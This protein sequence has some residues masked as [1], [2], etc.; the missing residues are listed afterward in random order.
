MKERRAVVVIAAAGRARRFGGSQKVL[1]QVGGIPSVCRVAEACERGLGPHRQIVVVG[2][3]GERVAAAL[4]P[5]G[6]REFV[7]QEE[8]R[9][10]GHALALAL[11]H[12]ADAGVHEVYFVCGDKPLLTAESLARLRDGFAASGAAMAFL[13]GEVAGDPRESR[14]GRVVQI[15]RDTPR[16]EVLAVVERAAI[17]ALGEGETLSFTALGGWQQRY[18]RDDLL[19]IRDVNVSAYV[20]RADVLRKHI[21]ELQACPESG[22]YLVT[23]LVRILREHRH[24]VRAFPVRRSEEGIGIDTQEVLQTANAV[25]AGPRGAT[26]SAPPAGPLVARQGVHPGA[27]CSAVLAA[28]EGDAPQVRQAMASIYGDHADGLIE[29]RREAYAAAVRLHRESF[30]ERPVRLF[31]APSRIALNPHCEHQGAWVPYGTHRREL[32][33]VVSP[34]H[35]DWFR[36]TNVDASYQ[37]DL[38]FRLSEE[39]DRAPASWQQGWAAY[40]EDD[41]VTQ[42]RDA[43]ADPR[44]RRWG[45]TGSINFIKAA[46]LRLAME[47][48]R[49]PCGADIVISGDIPLGRG[50]SSSSALVVAT[51]LALNE[52]WGLGLDRRE[53]AAICGEA[54]WYVGTRGGSGDHAAMLL[55]SNAGLVS[56]CFEPPVA[57]RDM[58]P[59]QMPPGYRILIVNSGQEAVKNKEERR[60]FNA[61]IFAYR[62][63]L[64]YLQE[65]LRRRADE[66][67]LTPEQAQVRFLAEVSTERFPLQVIYRLLRDVPQAVSPEVLKERYPRVYEAG[68]QGCF[69]TTDPD[70]IP[71]SIPVRG[72]ALYGLGRVDRGLAMHELCARGDEDAMREFG[73]LMYI[74]H[75]GDRVTRFDPVRHESSPY[76][77]NLDSVS[78]AHL[79][80]L[81]R[82]A[83]APKDTPQ[84]RQAQLRYQSGFY[85]ASTPELDRI[86]DIVAALPDVLG[87]GLM[88]AGG[89]G[90][91]LVL[92]RDRRGVLDRVREALER[93]YFGPLG[94]PAEVEPWHPTA[95]ACEVRLD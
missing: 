56:M 81:I 4:G 18:T 26:P 8:Q 37:A 44:E 31:R 86:V 62:F 92:T 6:H 69:G 89:G 71:S 29:R 30:G 58:R 95:P 36:L 93:G 19:A 25:L 83:A 87:A 64:L 33:A 23:D 15:H 50:Q 60:Q 77:A 47:L 65:A 34:R 90:C 38:A 85:G 70:A 42:Q 57:L 2:H 3:E 45:R 24:L 22:E 80:A 40:I 55:G 39:I 61:G 91:V 16:A 13:T 84:W 79:D 59:M 66:L 10:T 17:D 54:E 5:A 35:D 68:A 28:L 75:D 7:R 94:L 21:G 1:A 12:I 73:R 63:A 11:D 88:G 67:G 14:Q 82:A 49:A 20:W 32:L 78:D 53:L 41:A 51:A 9:G 48:P 52:L 46:A 76:S 27:P 43:L 72:A 74:T